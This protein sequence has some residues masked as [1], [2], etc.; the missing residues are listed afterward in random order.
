MTKLRSDDSHEPYQLVAF[1]L[2]EYPEAPLPKWKRRIFV[3]P[4]GEVLVAAVF[5]GMETGEF[6]RKA[7]EK[8]IRSMVHHDHFYV[9]TTWIVEV[10]PSFRRM[11]AQLEQKARHMLQVE[12][13]ERALSGE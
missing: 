4:T 10:K 5:F 3:L 1:L 12:L 11:C 9:P 13:E 2:D 8:Q 6:R 7:L